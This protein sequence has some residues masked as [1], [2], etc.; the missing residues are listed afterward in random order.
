M[1]ILIM[2][3]NNTAPSGKQYSK[4]ISE[5]YKEFVK[6]KQ[7]YL[8]DLKSR[9]A[10]LKEQKKAELLKQKEQQEELKKK[11]LEEKK[12]L[13]INEKQKLYREQKKE[14]DYL[15]ISVVL[16]LAAFGFGVVA[17]NYYTI[18]NQN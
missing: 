5:Q 12:K 18:N 17:V 9:A 6:R 14:R 1:R 11:M 10:K 16:L 8:E 7:L 15:A 3:S 4:T 2:T 13:L